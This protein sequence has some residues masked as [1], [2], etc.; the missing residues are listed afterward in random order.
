[1][2]ASLCLVAAC[3]TDTPVAIADSTGSPPIVKETPLMP[4]SEVP[5]QAMDDAGMQRLALN[6]AR[7]ANTNAALIVFLM[8]NP[9]GP[10]ADE[11]RRLL[12]AR[13]IPDP[14]GTASGPDAGV[15]AAFDAARLQG[16]AAGL[17]AF[18]TR[19]GPNPLVPEAERLLGRAP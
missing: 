16:S 3:V 13:R 6:E 4:E 8:R 1:L 11:A 2:L 10:R 12:D 5:P 18:I 15:I 7:A 14:P 19:Y 9:T 17:Q